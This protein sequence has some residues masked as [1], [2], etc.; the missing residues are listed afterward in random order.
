ME[1]RSSE[2]DR[3]H[4]EDASRSDRS[5]EHETGHTK[6]DL[7]LER[8]AARA[9]GIAVARLRRC[10]AAA[11]RLPRSPRLKD[12]RL[13]IRETSKPVTRATQRVALFVGETDE[14]T[15][16]IDTHTTGLTTTDHKEVEKGYRKTRIEAPPER[17]RLACT[18]AR[19]RRADTRRQRVR[20][21]SPSTKDPPARATGRRGEAESRAEGWER[22]L[23]IRGSSRA[24]ARR[25]HVT[26]DDGR[27]RERRPLD[28]E[29]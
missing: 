26:E 12:G 7:R 24:A 6:H 18:P 22:G 15:P 25:R 23:K 20:L 29:R 27:T 11:D 2:N 9:D 8:G 4:P 1:K 10:Q 13:G 19:C 21:Q 17:E 16:T 14:T 3:T 5:Y 28:R